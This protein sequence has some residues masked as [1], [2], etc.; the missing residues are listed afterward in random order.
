[1]EQPYELHVQTRPGEV[2]HYESVVEEALESF[3]REAASNTWA[4]GAITI[5]APCYDGRVPVVSLTTSNTA[6]NGERL[7]EVAFAMAARLGYEVYAPQLSAPIPSGRSN[8]I[9]ESMTREAKH[10]RHRSVA[11]WLLAQGWGSIVM[12]L[13]AATVIAIGI[14]VYYGIPRQFPLVATI[15]TVVMLFVT[16]AARRR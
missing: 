16:A 15:S 3:H 1:M 13:I 2:A 10:E 7:V 9:I 4:S 5:K 11:E 6:V 14:V 8:E 12:A